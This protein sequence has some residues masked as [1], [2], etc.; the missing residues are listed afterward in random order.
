MSRRSNRS[1]SKETLLT[2]KFILR[3]D[4]RSLLAYVS[5]YYLPVIYGQEC[6]AEELW[7]VPES[8]IPDP[9]TIWQPV[10]REHTDAWLQSIST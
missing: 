8:S 4:R 3:K 10:T 7:L 1:E 9:I 6:R 5:M 2:E